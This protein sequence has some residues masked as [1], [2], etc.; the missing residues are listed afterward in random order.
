MKI[1]IIGPFLSS[2]GTTRHVR[3]LFKGLTE[4]NP[5]KVVLISFREMNET[6][7]ISDFEGQAYV[8]DSI[9]TPH[10]FELLS[11]FICDIVI[12]NE[13]SVLLPQIKPFILLCTTL[14]KEKLQSKNVM[15]KIIGTWHSNFSWIIQAPFHHAMAY[16]G[17]QNTDTI[18]P[19]SNDVKL[20]LSK[21]LR[22]P[23]TR[24]TNIIP[25]GG[26]DFDL[27]S[28][29]RS[30]QLQELL[31][32]FS[33]KE[34][35]II[36]L[37]RLLYNKGIDT[38]IHA[39]KSLASNYLLVIVGNGPFE[40]KL[41]GI[42][43][44]LNLENRIIFTHFISDEEV[45]ALLQ[46]AELYC[47]PS[48]WESFSISTLEAMAAG[49]PIICSNVGGL[50]IW[51]AEA[52]IMVNPNNVE[53]LEAELHRVISDEQ[54]LKIH[55]E[56]SL[57]LA[58]KYDYKKIAGMTQQVI[59]KTL[60]QTIQSIDTKDQIKLIFNNKTGEIENIDLNNF[61]EFPKIMKITDFALYFPSEALENEEK[62][63]DNDFK[64]YKG[65]E[66]EIGGI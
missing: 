17:V 64:Y 21:H 41:N 51:A 13:I 28:K 59:D 8:F 24:I 33:I 36:F 60:N 1:A 2:S 22:F 46:G 58:K 26:I 29:N 32:R 66:N 30:N 52:A 53:E 11:E 57:N 27:I 40:Q 62:G 56:K 45:Y 6:L 63:G 35:Y 34:K 5:G 47:L 55:R 50:G 54:L 25:P 15:V 39:F 9:P 43:K 7:S 18:I 3:N 12:K 37:G 44:K 4:L 14:A 48:R 16:I 49:C 10:N 31:V 38:L 19:V 20:S 23:D 65:R 42:I 61:P